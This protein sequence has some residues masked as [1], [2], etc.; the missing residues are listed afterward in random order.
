[1]RKFFAAALA[2][3]VLAT[4]YV[5]VLLRRSIAAR[6]GLTIGVGTILGLAALGIAAPRQTVATAPSTPAP[7]A[8]AAFGPSI[9]T[10]LST[11]GGVTISFSRPMNEASVASAI[12]VTPAAGTRLAW[13]SDATAVTVYPSPAWATATF[14]TIAVGPAATDTAGVSLGGTTRSAF[15]TRA[16]TTASLMAT[17]QHGASTDVHTG[18]AI[19]FDHPVSVAAATAAFRISPTV[20]GTFSLPAGVT[21]ATQLVFTPKAPLDP[22]VAY[23]VSLDGSLT[24]A[25]GVSVDAPTGVSIHTTVGPSVVRFRPKNGTTDVAQAAALSVRFTVPMDHASTIAAFNATAAGKA[26]TGKFTWAEHD[27]VLVFTPS[28]RLPAGAAIKIS[29]ADTAASAAGVELGAP[30]TASATTFKVAPTTAKSGHGSGSGTPSP[31]P[32]PKPIPH[33]SGGSVGS[34][35]WHAVE[36]YYLRLMNC[37]RTGGWVTSNGSCSSPGGLSTNPIVLD[38]GLS[39]KVSRPYAKLLASN[40]ACDHFINGTPTDRL[41]RAGYSGWAAE[42][43]GC[44]SA[45]NGYASVL[46]T[47]LFFQDEKPCGGY[48]HYANLMN[49]AYSR[50]GIGVWIS[51]GRIRLV[52]DFYHS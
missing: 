50:C 37:T 15:V 38:K 5:P 9:K 36:V 41:H 1:M 42:N 39:D 33:S 6:V 14:Y 8:T 16:A 11:N 10:G 44:R 25:E 21:T 2:L 24:D 47:H 35:S 43:I 34:G 27:T 7:V 29:V 26:I 23:Q 17:K 49:P 3:P 52:I 40:G 12:G 20:E 51:G 4:L 30:A 19:T 28:V 18:F 31:K 13:N 32:K 22:D 48:C 46:G 45:S